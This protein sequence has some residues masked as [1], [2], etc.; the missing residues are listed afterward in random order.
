VQ[1]AHADRTGTSSVVKERIIFP[2]VP[3]PFRLR[4]SI[5]LITGEY[6]EVVASHTN[7]SSASAM[8][9]TLPVTVNAV[10]SRR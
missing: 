8:E 4:G 7:H 1:T 10:F 9:L 5:P 2:A 6:A 3:G